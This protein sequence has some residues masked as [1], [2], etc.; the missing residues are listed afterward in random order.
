MTSLQVFAEVVRDVSQQAASGLTFVR[1][2]LY[3][4]CL[5]RGVRGVTVNLW[6]NPPYPEGFPRYIALEQVLRDLREKAQAIL[7]T[8]RVLEEE[9]KA[10]VL[11]FHFPP[12]HD[13]GYLVDVRAEMWSA[14]GQLHSA[15]WSW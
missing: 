2:L 4:A 8:H 11:H 15:C 10:L 5:L 3:Q 9:V 14:D 6:S 13:E 12:G 1:P 7:A